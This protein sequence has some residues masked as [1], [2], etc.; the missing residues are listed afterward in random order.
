MRIPSPGSVGNG[1]NLPPATM[2]PILL[3]CLAAVCPATATAANAPEPA[4]ISL[5]GAWRFA[6]DPADEGVAG[7]WFERKL[8]KSIKLPGILQAQGF[9][10]P[11][12]PETPWVSGL[13]DRSWHLRADYRAYAIPGKTKV[14]FLCQPPRHYLGADLRQPFERGREGAVRRGLRLECGSRH[15]DLG[16]DHGS[17]NSSS[18][19][20]SE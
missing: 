13:H 15:R 1:R 12:G 16:A 3:A 18:E 9:G 17:G 19:C 4:A 6:L 7:K 10:D 5:A 8:E 20:S 14:P 2:K 11:V